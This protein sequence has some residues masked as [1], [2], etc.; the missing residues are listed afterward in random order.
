MQLS[1]YWE[2][3]VSLTN[4]VFPEHHSRH[5]EENQTDNDKYT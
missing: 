2:T 3:I 1:Y 5:L 4:P